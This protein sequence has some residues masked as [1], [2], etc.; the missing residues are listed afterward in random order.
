MTQLMSGVALTFFQE[1]V[2]EY[3]PLLAPQ[4]ET[5]RDHPCTY[6]FQGFEEHGN[7]FEATLC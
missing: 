3:S 4:I 6:E 5:R 7:H 2:I 1:A